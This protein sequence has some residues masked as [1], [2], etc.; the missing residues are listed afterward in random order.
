MRYDILK[1]FNLIESNSSILDL[2]CGDGELLL[3]LKN[4]KNA[5]VKGIDIDEKKVISSL[6]KGL[7]V[8]HGDM[9]EV[10]P[11]YRKDSYDYVILSLT[12]HQVKNPEKIIIEAARVGKNVIIS[13]PNFGYWKIRFNIFFK[14]TLPSCDYT[15][16]EWFSDKF[17]HFI[18]V[19]DFEKFCNKRKLKVLKKIFLPEFFAKLNPNL[20]SS[21][22]IYCL[23]GEK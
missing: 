16:Y 3:L 19:N 15:K 9:E 7:Q 23:R 21:S 13:F 20:L 18:T 6:K 11:H 10:L 2:G 17:V 22:A 8:Y 1:I 12:L 5:K 14:G 4:K